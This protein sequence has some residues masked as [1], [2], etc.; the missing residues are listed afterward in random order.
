MSKPP[1]VGAVHALAFSLPPTEA[2]FRTL[3][4]EAEVA[5]LTDGSLYLD[6]SK[7]TADEV[8]IA[9]RIGRLLNHSA[10][11]GAD[12][13]IF[14]GSFFGPAVRKERTGVGVPVLT[15]FEGIVTSALDLNQPLCVMSTAADSTVYLT[16]EIR[17]EAAI[18]GQDTDIES[19]VVKGA[20]EALGA[21]DEQA[22]NRRILEAVADIDDGRAVVMAQFTMERV[23]A[24]AS[25]LRSAPVI[26]PATEGVRQLRKT[27]E[28]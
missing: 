6:R 19:M 4:P 13:I 8:E 20:M 10:A 9:Q 3:W 16:D 21:G 2:A 27:Y 11:C 24:A 12:V 1:R 18:R 28:S 17:A 22:H 15:S 23:L 5:H 25:E 14:T 7:G 26:G